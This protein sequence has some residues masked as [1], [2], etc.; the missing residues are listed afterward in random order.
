[1]ATI[2]DSGSHIRFLQPSWIRQ[3]SWIREQS[4]IPAAILDPAAILNT[5]SHLEFWKPSGILAAILQN[6]TTII[7][8]FSRLWLV[9][10]PANWGEML[11]RFRPLAFHI[12][13]LDSESLIYFYYLVFNLKHNSISPRIKLSL[14]SLKTW[15]S[16]VFWSK[17]LIWLNL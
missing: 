6:P 1:M 7:Y 12:E 5:G 13:I 11:F 4:L 10:I 2:L 14:K 8:S 15:K 16:L 17:I 3:S 9:F